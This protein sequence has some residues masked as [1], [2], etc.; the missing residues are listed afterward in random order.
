[1][2]VPNCA[3][4]G[5]TTL[6]IDDLGFERVRKGSKER[7]KYMKSHGNPGKK[8]LKI[9]TVTTKEYNRIMNMEPYNSNY[10]VHE[11]MAICG[12]WLHAIQDRWAHGR[13]FPKKERNAKNKK[14][15]GHGKEKEADD[16]W[17]DW[18]RINGKKVYKPITTKKIKQMIKENKRFRKMIDV[19][20]EYLLQVKKSARKHVK[21]GFSVK[22]CSR[23]EVYNEVT[24]YLFQNE[25]KKVFAPKSQND[26][27]SSLLDLLRNNL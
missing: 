14:Y 18:G 6:D 15:L 26:K 2:K 20:Y 27:N 4:N 1:M 13:Y 22:C 21:K 19:T 9:Q 10:S 5:T 7:D 8:K 11:N 17:Y 3:L 16:I 24:K 25:F 23:D 12:V